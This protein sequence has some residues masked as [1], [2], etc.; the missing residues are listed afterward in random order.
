MKGLEL[1]ASI[2]DMQPDV[3]LGTHMLNPSPV[4]FANTFT[5]MMKEI[6]PSRPSRGTSFQSVCSMVS[7]R[8]LKLAVVDLAYQVP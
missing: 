5:S 2:S 4:L 7:P 8:A 1:A 6:A 3:P